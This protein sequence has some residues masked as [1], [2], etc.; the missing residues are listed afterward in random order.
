MKNIAIEAA[1]LY[2]GAK[3]IS[4]DSGGTNICFPKG[5]GGISLPQLIDCPQRYLTFYIEALVDHSVP[6]EIVFILKDSKADLKG[7]KIRFGI[8]PRFRT[9]ICIDLQWLDGNILFPGHTEGELKVVFLGGHVRREDIESIHL[10]SMPSFH[11]L[12]IKISQLNLS[13]ERP[14]QFPIP[15]EKL[16]DEYG[17]YK[18]KDWPGKVKSLGELKTRLQAAMETSGSFGIENWNGFGG[19]SKKKLGEGTGFFTKIKA[20]GRWWLVDPQG[21]AFFSSGPCCTVARAD[22][23]VDGIEK[24]MDWL[25]DRNDPEYASMYQ[26]Q[27]RFFRD[28]NCRPNNV[29]FSFEQANLYRALGKDWYEK[30]KKLIIG[31]LKA[32]GLNTLANWSDQDLFGK[33]EMSYVLSLDSF[34]E[35]KK[36]IFRDFPDVLSDEYAEDAR[37]CA[38][39]LTPFAN[40][41]RMIG[42]FLRNEPAW[43][44]VDNLVLAD[45]LLY[46]SESFVSK[47]KL[48]EFLKQKYETPEAL[49]KAWNYRYES[50]EDLRKPVYKASSFSR[51]AEAD[52]KEFSK[53]LLKTYVSIPSQECRKVAP[54]HMNLGMRWA[55]ISDPD[56]ISGW[57]NFDVFS[58][59]CY[60][61]DPTPALDNVV[62]LGVDLPIIIGEFH[63][64]A[65]DMGQTSTGLEGVTNQ[66]ERGK[67]YH[68]YTH[69]VA[70]HP[71]GVGCHWFQCYDQF[72]LGRFDGENYNIGLIDICSLPN[73]VMLKAVKECAKGIYGVMEGAVPPTKEKPE[74]IPMIAF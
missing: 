52:L 34:P 53:I 51:E 35:T 69:R 19:Y 30:W 41:P 37:Q 13:D 57:E 2:K 32:N 40:D 67:A 6:M 18:K 17:Q 59:N 63:F 72:A 44:F 58:I 45:E 65:L 48:I 28:K 24:L 23:R 11:D 9:L 50:F 42:Y 25:P 60:S 46:N 21:Y 7:H 74:S 1:A 4:S 56:L 49:S 71:N 31:Q 15:D 8:M 3:I 39:F 5:G 20:E 61:V 27:L 64:G 70:A 12:E 36:F 14:G 22:C 16:I 73:E 68:Y 66:V 29:V 47:D 10:V 54:H 62:K 38:A 33:V 43:A 55:W 26:E